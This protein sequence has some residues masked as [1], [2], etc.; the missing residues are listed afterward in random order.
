[1]SI[2]STDVSWSGWRVVN[3]AA[4][5]ERGNDDQGLPLKIGERF[6]KAL[7]QDTL[8]GRTDFAQALSLLSMNRTATFDRCAEHLRVS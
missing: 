5:G 2:P 7:V 1:M 8:E 6:S 3:G 4:A